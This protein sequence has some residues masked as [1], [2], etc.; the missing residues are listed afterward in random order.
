VK[1]L[2][3]KEKSVLV[4]DYGLF[5]CIA[6]RLAEDFGKVYYYVPWK[7]D[8]PTSDRDWMGRGIPGIEKI[9]EFHKYKDKVDMLCFCDMYDGDL[10][11]HLRN[12]GYKVFG[13]GGAEKFERN[14]W[15]FKKALVD[16]KL[17]VPKTVRVVGI[18][19]LRKYLS[20]VEGVKWLKTSE[21]RGD[22]ET[23]KH[24]NMDS[25]NLWIDDL[26]SKM[27]PPRQ[28]TIEILVEDAVEGVESG[29][30]GFVSNGIY[31]TYGTVGYEIKGDGFLCKV[32]KESELPAPIA[33]INKKTTPM[34]K[35]Y[36]GAYSTEVRV[37]KDG[38]PYYVDMSARFG[39]PPAELMC[40]LYENF[41]EVVWDLAHG[42]I[43]HPR[44]IAKYG[45]LIRLKSD[46][47][48]KRPTYIKYPKEIDRWVKLR[49]YCIDEKTGKIYGI[50]TLAQ[51]ST[52]GSVIGL[53]DSLESSMQLCKDR[54]SMIEGNEINWC[55]EIFAKGMAEIREGLKFGINL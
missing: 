2:N 49:D 20:S 44:P 37:G 32:F 10:Q 22:F 52:V 1:T 50:P 55:K 43:P 42:L 27:I 35:D 15:L 11:Q 53:S 34:L 8:F 46:W 45:S 23:Q 47:L 51:C 12:R 19:N 48:M 4:F 16:L 36:Y 40:E 6:K 41:S 9:R 5:I 30:D 33:L 3:L 18:D 38:I 13:A 28:A 21:F 24:E 25:T 14:R 17:S 29:W 7:C 26:A 54:A 39:S 31:S